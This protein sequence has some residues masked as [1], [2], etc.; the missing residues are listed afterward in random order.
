MKLLTA[1][2]VVVSLP[3]GSWAADYSDPDWPCIQRK[4]DELSVGLM[5]PGEVP[6]IELSPEAE[7]LA[8][9]LSLRRV[10]LEDAE[11]E[12][13]A[14]TA[15]NTDAD[16]TVLG[17]IFLEVFDRLDRLRSR[18]IR[19]IGDYSHG[20]IARAARIDAV[21][22]ELQDMQAVEDPDEEGIQDLAQRL[23]WEERI[24]KDRQDSLTYVCETPVLLEKRLYAV[25]QMLQRAVD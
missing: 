9:L 5:W 6:E 12:V 25:A 17:N 16:A 11:A 3:A 15:G 18:L 10:S 21:R 8:E 7:D 4:V 20:Q 13:E 22:Q 24:Y 23:A 1:A 2:L 14:F 19:G